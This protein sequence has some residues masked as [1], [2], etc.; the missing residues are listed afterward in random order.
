MIDCPHDTLYHDNAMHSDSVVC[1]C[2]RRVFLYEHG[3]HNVVIISLCDRHQHLHERRPAQESTQLAAQ[4]YNRLFIRMSYSLY[5]MHFHVK[6]YKLNHLTPTAAMGTAALRQISSV[7][8][9]L[10]KDALLTLLR[11][12]VVSKVDCYSTVLAGVSLSLSD[13]LHHHHHHHIV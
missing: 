2:V 10:T 5:H 9:S 4:G 1:A 7:R 8:R 6:C 3:S 12:L 11:A 13:R